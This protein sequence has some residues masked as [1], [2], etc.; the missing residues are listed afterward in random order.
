MTDEDFDFRLVRVPGR[1]RSHYN[2]WNNW[3]T[4]A[5][6]HQRSPRKF[7]TTANDVCVH[8]N[9]S[10]MPPNRTAWPAWI[11]M[12]NGVVTY[13]VSALRP[14]AF[15]RLRDAQRGPHRPCVLWGK[16]ISHL[17][18]AAGA[19]DCRTEPI[20]I[21]ALAHC[22]FAGKVSRTASLLAL[23]AV[24]G[25][26]EDGLRS[27]FTAVE[28][29]LVKVTTRF[30]VHIIRFPRPDGEIACSDTAVT[31][32]EGAFCLGLRDLCLAACCNGSN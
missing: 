31:R 10:L 15:E 16:T 23:G 21:Q 14:R 19:A 17:V 18:L 5:D 26:H 11:A 32:N 25:F 8:R 6:A 22:F 4:R 27:A 30:V 1:V 12:P 24:T 3:V 28:A 7:S 13:W 20:E 9:A 29:V 2:C